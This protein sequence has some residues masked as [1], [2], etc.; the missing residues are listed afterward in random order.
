MQRFRFDTVDSTNEQAK[1][2]LA[3][4]HIGELA[5]VTARCQ[6]AGKGTRGRSW[7]S[8]RDAGI[9][10]SVVQV[11]GQ[12]PLPATTAYTLAAG[13]ACVETLIE[14][15]GATVHLKPINDIYLERGKLGGILTEA[16]THARGMAV[17][18]TGVGINLFRADR[19]AST[20]GAA[21]TCLEDALG[22]LRMAELN[23]DELIEALA[24][25]IGRWNQVVIRGDAQRVR[26]AWQRY[27]LPGADLPPC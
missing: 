20:D 17:L 25:G 22:P 16:V 5:C 1:R 11:G 12:A 4:G 23:L 7:V 14:M 24:C 19:P 8:P 27:A 15:T 26:Q 6:T 18:I 10:L 3:T 9:Y 2:L 13:V 21:A